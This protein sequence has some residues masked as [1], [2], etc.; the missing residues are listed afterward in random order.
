MLLKHSELLHA[1]PTLLI[2]EGGADVENTGWKGSG[3]N[4]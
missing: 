4:L 1:P 2:R 3:K